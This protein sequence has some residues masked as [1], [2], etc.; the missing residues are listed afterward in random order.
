MLKGKKFDAFTLPFGVVLED[1]ISLVEKQV[2]TV[3]SV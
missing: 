1:R 3:A 2:G